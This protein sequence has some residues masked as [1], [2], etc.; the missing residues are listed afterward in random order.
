MFLIFKAVS[1]SCEKILLF[2]FS[3]IVSH[4]T[5]T[6]IMS[7]ERCQTTEYPTKRRQLSVGMQLIQFFTAI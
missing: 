7:L 5:F 1:I 3:A 2:F 6:F 4:N